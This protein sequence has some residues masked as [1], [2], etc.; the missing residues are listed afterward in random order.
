MKTGN[1]MFDDFDSRY[2]AV[3]LAT[4]VY[5]GM[6]NAETEPFKHRVIKVG[7]NGLLAWGLGPTLA[8]YLW[9]SEIAAAILMMSAGWIILDVITGI[10]AD[11]KLISE[12]VRKKLGVSEQDDNGDKK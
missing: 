10:I 6:K 12:L 5:V 2:W 7:V 8:S 1:N 4:A 9:S 11:P 3:F